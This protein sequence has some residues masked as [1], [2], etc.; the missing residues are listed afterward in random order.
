MPL[1]APVMT[2]TLF[3]MVMVAVLIA[4]NMYMLSM[5]R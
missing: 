4:D 1:P 2:T 3:S 5:V